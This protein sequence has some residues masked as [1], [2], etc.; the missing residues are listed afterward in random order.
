M[1]ATIATMNAAVAT[2][3]WNLALK[4]KNTINGPSSVASLNR[5]CGWVLSIH[6][7]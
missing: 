2:N 4:I 5:G 3:R 6:I 1:A 7:T